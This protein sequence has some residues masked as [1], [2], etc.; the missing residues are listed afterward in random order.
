MV[1]RPSWICDGFVQLTGTGL[2]NPRTMKPQRLEYILKR[3]NE[4]LRDI[5]SWHAAKACDGLDRAS[6]VT[7]A[8]LTWLACDAGLLL[9]DNPEY[10]GGDCGT[11]IL[12][13]IGVLFQGLTGKNEHHVRTQDPTKTGFLRYDKLLHLSPYS[14][15]CNHQ[16]FKLW[17]IQFLH[18]LYQMVHVIYC[19]LRADC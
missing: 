16:D 14:S 1:C 8:N 9:R 19:G 7:E 15:L 17:N 3:L 4:A 12:Q 11:F 6:A 2:D 10:G 5:L 18:F 13:T